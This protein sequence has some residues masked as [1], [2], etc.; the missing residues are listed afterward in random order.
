MTEEK[1]MTAH[2]PSVG[3]DGGRSLKTN[4][5]ASIFSIHMVY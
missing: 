5:E 4:C 2:D 1:R 3:A